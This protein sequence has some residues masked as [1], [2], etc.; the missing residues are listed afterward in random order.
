MEHRYLGN[1]TGRTRYAELLILCAR[2]DFT[3]ERG[4]FRPGGRGPPDDP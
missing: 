3:P 2:I 1:A 4:G